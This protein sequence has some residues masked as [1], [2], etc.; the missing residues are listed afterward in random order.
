MPIIN[1]RD[2]KNN[3]GKRKEKKKKKTKTERR[4][5]EAEVIVKVWELNG[6]VA[7]L[8]LALLIILKE[9]ELYESKHVAVECRC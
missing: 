1:V 2:N 9:K 7:R 8:G 6:F 3:R 4:K 5:G